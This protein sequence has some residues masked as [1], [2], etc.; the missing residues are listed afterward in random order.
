MSLSMQEVF[1][2]YEKDM[3]LITKLNFE[4]SELNAG[5]ELAWSCSLDVCFQKKMCSGPTT[6]SLSRFTVGRQIDELL[7]NIE[8]SLKQKIS[9][10]SAFSIA[11]GKNTDVSNTVQLVFW[12]SH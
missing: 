7:K 12:L 4:I 1:H 8:L 10:S 9:K 5:K 6:V 2:I 11:L 3:E